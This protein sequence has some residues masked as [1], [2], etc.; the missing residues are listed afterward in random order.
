MIVAVTGTPC[1]GK[2]TLSKKLARA[3]GF[4]RIDL[5]ELIRLKGWHEGCDAARDTLI[6]NEN[7]LGG[8]VKSVLE[9]GKDYVLDSHLSH[10]LPPRMVSLCIVCT[11]DIAVLKGRLKKRGYS[12][13]KVRE[14]L[15]AEIFEECR[16]EAE[17]AGHK[18]L[19][20]DTTKPVDVRRLAGEVRS[21]LGIAAGKRIETRKNHARLSA[22]R[23]RRVRRA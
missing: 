11:C 22:D 4:G 5:N 17:E 7:T 13:L 2:S 1:A 9:R 21:L 15:D 12:T 10:F 20:V 6:V 16:T 18:V 19:I 3:L 23:A 8:R 14:N